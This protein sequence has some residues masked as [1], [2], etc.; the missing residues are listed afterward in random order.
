VPVWGCG[1]VIQS[2]CGNIPEGERLWGY[3]P[4]G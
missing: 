2:S 3:F 1:T 4:H